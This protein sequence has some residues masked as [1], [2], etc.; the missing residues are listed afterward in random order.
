MIV[1]AG[2]TKTFRP[3][4]G[5]TQIFK[6]K[7]CVKALDGVSLKVKKGEVFALLGP[8]GAGKTTLI[9]IFCSLLLPDSGEVKIAGFNIKTQSALAKRSIGIVVGEERSFYWRLT[10]RQN[11]SFFATLY[12]LPRR[13]ARAKIDELA[14]TLQIDEMDKRYQ[15]CST[16]IKQRLAIARCLLS[17]A[18]VIF[19]DEPTRSLDPIAASEIR[20]MIREKLAGELGKTVFFT[21]HQ[22]H[23]A[24]DVADRIAVIDHGRIKVEGSPERLRIQFGKPGASLEEIFRWS[25]SL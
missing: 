15:E 11:L 3:G 12:N 23:E 10:C 19:M 22:T 16:G 20:K 2:V 17:D 25:V 13:S 9:K 14:H 5:L 7:E 24:E 4:R 1:A 8:N 21:T 6:K 18:Q